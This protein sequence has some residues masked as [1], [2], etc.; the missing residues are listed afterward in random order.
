MYLIYRT[1]LAVRQPQQNYQGKQ[2]GNST[3]NHN[4]NVRF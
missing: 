2:N 3:Q 4:Q 1:A